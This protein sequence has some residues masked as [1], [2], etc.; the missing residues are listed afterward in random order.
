MAL[1][2]PFNVR[3]QE[4]LQLVAHYTMAVNSGLYQA[5][6]SGNNNNINGGGSWV[7]NP[8]WGFTTNAIAGG[9]ALT[10]D[11]GENLG[12]QPGQ[13]QQVFDS[14]LATFY[15]SFSISLWVNTTNV[16]GNDSDNLNGYNDANI[17]DDYYDGINDAI[18]IALTGHKVAFFT[19]DPT[20]NNGDTLHSM[21]SVTTGNWVH[22]VVTRDG[23]TGQKTIYINGML[24]NSDLGVPNNLD[25]NTN[26]IIIGGG[27]GY[28]YAGALD[29]LQVYSGVLSSNDVAFLYA[30]PGMVVGNVP[31]NT[32]NPIAFYDFDESTPYAAD[33][34]ADGY[35]IVNGGNFGGP[36]LTSNS[37]SGSGAVYFNGGS[38][39]TPSSNLLS[40]LAGTF[41]LSL[42]VKTIQFSGYADNEPASAGSGIVSAGVLN[43]STNDLIPVALTGGAIGF[44]TGNTNGGDTINSATDINDGNYHHVVVTRNEATGEKQIYIDGALSVSDITNT[45]SLNAPKLIS[46]GALADAGNPDPTSPDNTG[47]N[48]FIGSVDDIQMYSRVLSSSQVAFLYSNPGVTITSN[49]VVHYNFDEGTVLAA[50]VSGNGNNVVYAGS[51]PGPGPEM[52]TNAASGLSALSFDGGSYLTPNNLVSN[53]AGTFSLSVW[54]ATTQSLGG[55]GEP[56]NEGAGVV[57]AQTASQSDDLTPIALTGGNV[58]FQTDGNITDVLTSEMAINDGNYH[59]VVV[60]RDQNSGE[61]QIYIDGNLDAND[62]ADTALLNSPQ[63]VILGCQADAS[64][65]N[66]NSPA[67]DGFNGFAGLMDQLQVYPRVISANEVAYLY[68]NPGATLG[69]ETNSGSSPPPNTNYFGNALGQPGLAWTTGGNASWFVETTNTYLNNSAAAQSGSMTNSDYIAVL[70]TTVTGA[71]EVSFEW[72]TMAGNDDQF[73]LQFFIDGNFQK[74]ITGAWPWTPESFYTT[75]GAHTLLWQAAGAASPSDAG[76]LDQV[77]ITPS[78]APVITNNPF[79]QTNYPG[80]DV[81]LVAGATGTP[82]PTWQWYQEGNPSPLPGATSATYIPSNSGQ[83]S[84][85][86]TYYAIASNNAGSAMTTPAAVTF[87]NAPAP[88]GWAA[89]SASPLEN[90]DSD[91][92]LLTAPTNVYYSCV[93]DSTGTNEFSSGYAIGTNYYYNAQ[94]QITTIY[95]QAAAIIVKQNLTSVQ[96][97]VAVT[98]NGNGDAY[99]EGLALAPNGG[100]YAVGHFTGAN[101]L[102]STLL[103][104]SGFGTTF[105]A[106][107][108]ANGNPVWITTITNSFPVPVGVVSDASGNVTLTAIVNG[109]TTIAGTNYPGSGQ[110]SL[111]AQFNSAGA[112]NWV[113]RSSNPVEYLA[114]GFGRIYAS[115]FNYFSTN[116]S[117]AGIS[118]NS[119]FNWSVAAVNSTNGNG[120]WLHGVGEAYGNDASSLLDDVPEI[121]VSSNNVFLVGT[122][123][124][125]NAV[126]G[127]YSVGITNGRGQYFARYDTGG[128]AQLADGFGGDTAQP[129][130]AAASPSGN[131][132][133]TGAFDTYTYFGNFILAGP[134]LAAFG[135]GY[136]FSQAFLAKFNANGVPQWA[137][138]AVSDGGGDVPADFITLFDVSLG[139]DNVWVAGAGSGPVQFADN[140]PTSNEINT[141]GLSTISYPSGMVGYVTDNPPV[142][143]ILINAQ[144]AHPGFQFSFVSDAGHTN[145]VQYTTNLLKGTWQA[146]TNITGDGTLKT[147]DVPSTN[148]PVEFFRV[149]TQ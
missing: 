99:A 63:I 97:V 139:G 108:D 96:W 38:F 42:W 40:T 43:A 46:I 16:L 18:P 60:T 94:N 123:Y 7:P 100:V 28:S 145:Y 12:F 14:W 132:Y 103:Q 66:P 13:G 130:A 11:G 78:V 56:A 147:I 49:L 3:G 20:G 25:G 71:C 112:L 121:A 85:A 58:V 143:V 90:Y 29:D 117:I 148:H 93:V 81:V 8:N 59:H 101:W 67:S 52:T 113:D 149:E 75:P 127:A 104:D 2:R 142:S 116:D 31:G 120:V 51:F 91:N 135:S 79:S 1:F 44:Y 41:S 122:A 105:L 125:S 98:N 45:G 48:G 6:S 68:N 55:A 92:G 77:V 76:F 64:Q 17:I 24:D 39:L 133:V 23:G 134:H 83:S 106:Q 131:V 62:V 84:V 141:G 115:L 37:V 111:V 73:N 136:D 26:N 21:A 137:L 74:Q 80:Y 65:N 22:I 102:G 54:L 118:N 86:G 72:Q 50:D 89:A 138:Q 126:F 109:S 144:A 140:Y 33:L 124:G 32:N 69:G 15:G 70:S 30:N 9:G 128:N 88:P 57:T 5:D 35:N 146:Y 61:K 19:G 27:P 87:V 10:L 95:G 34:T 82:T 107:F 114:G 4:E 47:Y 53:F 119:A 36:V 110:T 129:F